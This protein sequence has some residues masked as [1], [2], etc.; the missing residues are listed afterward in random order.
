MNSNIMTTQDSKKDQNKVLTISCIT[1]FGERYSYYLLQ[2]LLILFLINHFKL[3]TQISSSLVG[4]VLGMI[5]ISAII[6]GIVADK[7]LGYY[8][9][10]FIGTA[11]MIIGS[12]ILAISDS[13]SSVY[14]GLCFVSVSTGLIK[15]N[16]SS[17]IGKFYDR[18][19]LSEANRDFGFNVFYVGINIGA[20]ASQFVAS[21]LANKFG[22]HVA[23]S[24]SII[25]SILMLINMLIGFFVLK[26]YISNDVKVTLSKIIQAT[27]I[28]VAYMGLVYLVL[29]Y[30]TLAD[31]AVFIS[32]AVSVVILWRA[33]QVSKGYKRIITASM[34]FI[35]SVMYWIL[36]FQLF[37]S[38]ELFVDS[39]VQKTILSIPVNTTQI[40]STESVAILIM[41]YFMG[42]FW[43]YREK[44]GKAVH[45]IDKFDLAFVLMTI[46]FIVFYLVIAIIPGKIPATVMAALFFIMAISELCLSAI[47]LSMV[48]KLAPQ[49]FVSLFM[50][51]WLVTLGVGGK[52]AGFISSKI[53]ITA[54]NIAASKV[55]MQHGILIFIAI[56]VAAIAI[57]LL[58]RKQAIAQDEMHRILKR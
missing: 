50:S 25:A 3:S 12:S 22:Y 39:V 40:I 10:A 44:I 13:I 16:I 43:I 23:F 17:F 26:N 41:G 11:I 2:S 28:I 58:Y 55:S 21:T 27:A 1:E 57:C 38:I 52:I 9:S 18:S 19:G 24:S 53:K 30:N 31:V 46:M 45:D 48:T 4:S 7:L 51:I 6:G 15:S 8:R 56:S 47:G 14:L 34:F 49:G 54:D 37:I 35:L 36:Y 42:K 29:N 20:F 33:A 32:V 5:Y